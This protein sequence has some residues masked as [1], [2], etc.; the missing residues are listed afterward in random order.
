MQSCPWITV[1]PLALAASFIIS[2]HI[3]SV[4]AALHR[5]P[6]LKRYSLWLFLSFFFSLC[7]FTPTCHP[8]FFHFISF[9]CGQRAKC[10]PNFSLLR[11]VSAVINGSDKLKLLNIAESHFGHSLPVQ[12]FTKQLCTLWEFHWRRMALSVKFCAIYN[13]SPSHGHFYSKNVNWTSAW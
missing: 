11:D 13:L 8:N 4:C 10:R 9:A 6:T 1:F 3:S 2:L 5:F 12:Q 7:S